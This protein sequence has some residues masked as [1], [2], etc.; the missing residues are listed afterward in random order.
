MGEGLVW[1]SKVIISPSACP[2]EL[3]RS[4]IKEVEIQ[5]L[6]EKDKVK[7]KDVVAICSRVNA[8]D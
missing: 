5:G 2:A 8:T 7:Q 3:D 1:V 4:Y 6:W